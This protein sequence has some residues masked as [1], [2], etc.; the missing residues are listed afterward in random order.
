MLHHS[1]LLAI[2]LAGAGA[3]PPGLDW[4]AYVDGTSC[5]DVLPDGARTILGIKLDMNTLDAFERVLG[6]SPLSKEGDAGEYFEWR[7]WAAANGDGTV[8]VV[9]RGEVDAQV[10]V[11]G[12]G[13]RFAGRGACPKSKL[14]SRS[15]ATSNGVRIGLTRAEIER[16]VGPATAAGTGWHD[17]TC[18]GKKP[19]TEAERSAMGAGTAEGWDVSS[20]VTV[21]EADGR[22]EGFRLVWVVTF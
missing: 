19:M 12:R 1:A 22:A 11:L 8:L 10:R 3:A 5:K 14:V 15:L 2:M 20:R 18:L 4:P 7:C 17:R 13:M 21:V 16:K 9:G 6:A